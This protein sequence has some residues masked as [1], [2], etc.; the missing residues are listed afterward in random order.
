MKTVLLSI[1]FCIISAAA[2]PEAANVLVIVN[3]VTVAE[4]GT[5]GVGASQFVAN[6]YISVRG[7]P[8]SNVVH[9]SAKGCCG[10]ADGTSPALYNN[11]E[12]SREQF[13]S[14]IANPIKAFLEAHNLKQQ[15]KYIVP[16][17]GVPTNIGQTPGQ[18]DPNWPGGGVD[19]FLSQL[20]LGGV[21]S[22]TFNPAYNPIPTSTP[23]HWSN[24]T[25]ATPVYLVAR[26]DGPSAIIANGLVDKAV[27]AEQG[28]SKSSGTGYFDFQGN[29]DVNDSTM[30]NAYNLCV[31]AGMT[32]NLNNQATSGH[33]YQS[34]P[35]TLWAWGWY[36][37]PGPGTIYTFAPGA[38][39]AQLVSD[40]A[41]DIRAI[42][43]SEP[44][45]VPR[46][47]TDGITATWGSVTEPF[48]GNFSK[49]DNILWHMWNGYTFGESAYIATPVIGWMM[50]FVG[51]PLYKPVFGTVIPPP[52]PVLPLTFSITVG[53]DGSITVH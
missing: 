41:F 39:G 47:L 26:L 19:S 25:A 7:I 35:N 21:T 36:G 13:T 3:D 14:D 29:G 6:H 43:P 40:S 52:P 18:S 53:T 42:I 46:F 5:G 33:R 15:I 34:A 49:G 44:A 48:A 20:Y 11:Y 23:P 28:I 24:L 8:L 10:F 4:T 22:F 1:L 31:S 9:I 50:M 51:D 30:L 37:G 16:T 2:N 12:L 17:Y 32:C 45:W 38:V 27:A